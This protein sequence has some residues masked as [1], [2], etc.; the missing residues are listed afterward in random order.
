MKTKSLIQKLLICL[1]AGLICGETFLR[2]GNRFLSF[3]LPIHIVMGISVAIALIFMIYAFVWHRRERKDSIDSVK[4]NAFWVGAIRYG[5]AFDLAM[6]GF[7]KIF[8]LQFNTPLGMLDEP[9]SSFGNQ[10]HVWSFF[11]HSYGFAVTIAVSQIAGSMLL[12]FN[13]TRLLGAVV[14]FPVM[15]NIIFIDYFYDLDL[16]VLM[17]ALI[18]FAGLIYLL[19]MDYDRLVEF[20]LKHKSSDASVNTPN[21]FLK[22]IGR[23]H[24]RCHHHPK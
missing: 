8:H 18:L 24:D 11:G 12:L 6:F 10:W 20:F 17:H 16:G 14:L 9:F 21:V 13:R 7:Q 1:L 23:H 3:V 15:L 2:V 19:M 5:I 4:V 22:Y